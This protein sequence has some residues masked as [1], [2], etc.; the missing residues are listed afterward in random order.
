[1]AEREKYVDIAKAILILAVV[2][3]HIKISFTSCGNLPDIR[4]FIYLWHVPVFFIIAGFFLN[5]KIFFSPV[6]FIKRKVKTLYLKLIIIYVII[7]LF[8]N[9]FIDIGWYDVNHDYL[10]KYVTYWTVFDFV[11]NIVK[12][13]LLSGREVILGAMWFVYVLFIALCGFSIVSYISKRLESKKLSFEKIRFALVFIFFVV[14]YICTEYGYNIP[15]INNSFTAIWLIYIGYLIKV[16]YGIRFDNLWIAISGLIIVAGYTFITV[17]GF[18]LNVNHFD[19]IIM[20][21]IVSLCAIYFICFLSKKLS[22]TFLSGVLTYIGRNSFYIMAFHFIGFKV[23]SSLL[24]LI[25]IPFTPSMV[26]N[27]G[28]NILLWVTYILFGTAV[29]LVIIFLFNKVKSS[30]VRLYKYAKA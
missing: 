24:T 10:G 12:A 19:S 13:V 9:F 18:S 8:H 22:H 17:D 28:D 21:T 16:K 29:P 25:D 14:A 23:C 1:M 11:E 5:N 4:T 30:I 6:S 15:R 7:L 26:P 2:I 20:L 27:V 3:G